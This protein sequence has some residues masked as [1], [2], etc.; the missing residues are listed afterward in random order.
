MTAARAQSLRRRL[1][2]YGALTESV[3]SAILRAIQR[4]KAHPDWPVPYDLVMS[5]LRVAGSEGYYDF[6]VK[7]AKQQVSPITPSVARHVRLSVDKLAGLDTDIHAPR[8]LR[9]G[10]HATTVLFLHGGGYVTCSPRSHRDVVARLAQQAHARC[11]VPD[12]RLAP[13]HP[14]PAALDD[15]LA[16]Y[17]ALLTQGVAPGSLVVAGD[18]AGGGLS[19]ALA[20]RLRELGEP[21]PAGLVLLS[22]W[23]DL[24]LDRDALERSDHGDYLGPGSLTANAAQYAGG[25]PLTSPLISPVFAD[26][27][28]LPPILMETGEWENLCEQDLRFAEL[29][30]EAGVR[31]QHTVVPGLLHAFVCFS[32]VLPQGVASLARA[33]EFIRALS[34]PHVS[35]AVHER[36]ASPLRAHTTMRRSP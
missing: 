27:S 18:S 33:G 34:L 6:G 22:P 1:R 15:A 17:R 4:Q 16:C 10:E 2:F 12:Y 7:L 28:G 21:L 35:A 3:G 5:F 9:P 14:F 23:V 31:V 13:E 11:F 24:S 25:Y 36:P 20:V 8:N 32:A 26:L 30:R 29:A 19:V